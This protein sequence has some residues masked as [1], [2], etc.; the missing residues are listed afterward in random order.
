MRTKNSRDNGP[1]GTPGS[2]FKVGAIALAF[3]IIGYQSA[4]FLH[5]AATLRIESLRDRPDTVFVVDEALA[6][7][8]LGSEAGSRS[9]MPIQGA[10]ASGEEPGGR[11]GRSSRDGDKSGEEPVGRDG[12]KNDGFV[13]NG[14]LQRASG[15]K[16]G[17]FVPNEGLQRASGNKNDGF[18]PNGEGRV[19]IRRNAPHSERVQQVRRATRRIE[20]FKFNPN[21]VSVDDLVRLGFT[22]KQA[23][24]IDN[25]RAAGGRF[26]RPGD[27]ARSYVV[28]DSVFKRLEPWIVIPKTDINK[29]DSAAFDDLPGIGPYFA[30]KMVSYRQRLGG[31]SY[32]EQLMDIY[33]FD[34]QKYD[35]L[36]DLI[37]CSRPAEPF[38]LWSLGP[39]SLRL[40]PYIRDWQTARSIVLF[41]ENTPRDG[42]TVEALSSAG[43]LP[44]E[45]ASRLARCYIE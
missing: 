34:R 5:K 9:D 39:D 43:I 12:N 2:V 25:Y 14:G 45:D 22:E 36:S 6:A 40:H 19:I 26:R 30:A 37:S 28:A 32:K 38:R 27:F 23:Q 31:Y 21:T 10:E 41:R 4:L 16:N 35:G 15:N 29:A 33:R 11:D 3:L 24:S 17:G 20:N 44:P 42:W 1:E 7:R 8:L 18:V 13:P